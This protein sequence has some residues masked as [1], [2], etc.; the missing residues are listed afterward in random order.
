MSGHPYQT[1]WKRR[2][3]TKNKLVVI[4]KQIT[5]NEIRL[6]VCVRC[7]LK[8]LQVTSKF[9]FTV[10]RSLMSTASVCGSGQNRSSISQDTLPTTTWLA[11][12]FSSVTFTAETDR[13]MKTERNHKSSTTTV[14]TWSIFK[15]EPG[16]KSI[17]P[18]TDL[19]KRPKPTM[20]SACIHV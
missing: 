10:P 16:N 20:N 9:S 12:L 15:K 8:Y 14:T 11:R 13:E 4:V 6:E 7:R 18:S 3:R 5:N 17:F 19:S 1:D 2:K